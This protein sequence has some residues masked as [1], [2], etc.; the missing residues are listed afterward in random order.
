MP[1][2]ES[3][4]AL[5]GRGVRAV[6]GGRTVY[7][8]GPALLQSLGIEPPAA[9]RAAAEEAGRSGQTAVYVVEER[10]AGTTPERRVLA[11]LAVA[12]A[13]R[14]ES[15]EAVDPCIAWASTSS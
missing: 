5:A 12:D 7:V 2:A 11:A 8:G 3:F 10:G 14:P 9:V 4:E 15:R 6:V 13:V 1:R